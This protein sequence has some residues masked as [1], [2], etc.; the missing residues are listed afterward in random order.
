[1]QF[2]KNQEVEIRLYQNNAILHTQRLQVQPAAIFLGNLAGSI[3]GI[4]GIVG[5]VMNKFESS[6]E[7]IIRNINYK[8]R[9]SRI[10]NNHIQ[11][12][13]KNFD[14]LYTRILLQTKRS[15]SSIDY[16]YPKPEEE[17]GLNCNSKK[18]EDPMSFQVQG[19]SPP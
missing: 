10:I 14:M 18:V 15:T 1:M 2:V 4:L 3:I 7:H 5:F 11:I 8:M 6:Y 9:R 13:S 17:N 16:I 19:L 12:I